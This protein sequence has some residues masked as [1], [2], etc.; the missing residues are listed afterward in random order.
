MSQYWSKLT[1]KV[2]PYTPGEQPKDKKYIKLNTNESPYPPS[3]KAVEA[4][5]AAVSKD[6]QLYPDPTSDI[7]VAAIADYCKLH[8]GQIFVG[9]G[10]DEVL[11]FSF[12]A[13]FD[14]DRPI[15]YPD[16]TYSF[17]PVY[18]KVFDISYELVALDEGFS[19]PVNELCKPN[20]GVI[21]ANPNAPTGKCMALDDVE[22]IL[23]ANMDQVVIVD[24]AYI[25]FG[26][27]TAIPLIDKYPNLLVVQTFS[28]SRSLA[29]LR[30]GFAAGHP[31]LIEGL[32]RIKNSFN[33]YTID[34]VALAGA[35]ASIQDDEYFN[36]NKKHDHRH[37]GE[38][39]SRTSRNGLQS[40]RLFGEFHLRI[41]AIRGCSGCLY[42]AARSGHPGPVFQQTENRQIPSDQHR[43]GCGNGC[44][45]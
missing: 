3:P 15:L 32:N 12:M 29:G 30:V 25:D 28:K 23:K 17:Y 21:F 10:S 20:G 22:K 38:N 2:D 13:F 7:L 11:G 6:L 31:H 40:H 18:S 4:M 35:T 9:N 24:E 5:A 41:T 39:G 16:I 26:G 14:P 45:S 8:K 44:F 19:I 33:S 27:D 43:F 37:Q 36:E 1:R 42:Q 34:R